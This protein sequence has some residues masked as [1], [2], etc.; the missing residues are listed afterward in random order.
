MYYGG[1][2]EKMS[3]DKKKKMKCLQ[4]YW[5]LIEVLDSVPSSFPARS[6]VTMIYDTSHCDDVVNLSELRS[7]YK[8]RVARIKAEYPDNPDPD[9]AAVGT[10]RLTTAST[11]YDTLPVSWKTYYNTIYRWERLLILD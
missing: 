7:D 1:K 6:L 5:S 11:L 4:T 8:E 10:L 3:V 9:L 2:K